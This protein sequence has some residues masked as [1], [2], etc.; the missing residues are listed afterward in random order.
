MTV[1]RPFWLTFSDSHGDFASGLDNYPGE[2]WPSVVNRRMIAAGISLRSKN[3]GKGGSDDVTQLRSWITDLRIYGLPV[4]VSIEGC[5]NDITGLDLILDPNA[6]TAPVITAARGGMYRQALI[7]AALFEVV[8]PQ[9]AYGD[10]D[11]LAYAAATATYPYIWV[12]SVAEL[13][14]GGR[15][16]E[17][18][19]LVLGGNPGDTDTTGGVPTDPGGDPRQ[20]ARIGGSV[21]PTLPWV[22]ECATPLAGR[23]GYRRVAGVGTQPWPDLGVKFVTSSAMPYCNWT[24]SGDTPTVP[25]A[26]LAPMRAAKKAATLSF[27]AVTFTHPRYGALPCVVWVDHYARMAAAITAGEEPNFAVTA[28]DAARSTHVGD[29][30]PHQNPHGMNRMGGDVF[31][32]IAT[33]GWLPA[34]GATDA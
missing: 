1:T 27:A 33:A 29:G 2:T 12:Q 34:L 15:P 18:R 8:G 31:T 30:N 24:A 4:G 3:R 25:R 5:Q 19:Y 21:D 26:V 20:H 22:W 17:Q 32:A 16:G 11:A 28:Y 10:G 14:A 23:Y 6:G 9:F 7:L 13:P